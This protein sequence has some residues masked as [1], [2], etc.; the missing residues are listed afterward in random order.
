MNREDFIEFG[1]VTKTNRKTAEIT[2]ATEVALPDPPPA[3]EIIFLEIDGGLVP[4]FLK[5]FDVRA[6]YA[7]GLVEDY[8]SPDKAQKL[9]GCRVFIKKELLAGGSDEIFYKAIIGF[10]VFDQTLGEI[11]RIAE[12]FETPHQILLQVIKDDREILIPLVE[13]FT[14]SINKRKK[15]LFMD[16][17]EGLT[18][19]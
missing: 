12:I 10:A 15:Q 9:V 3:F 13:E 2:I 7:V 11:G 19:L 5:E 14:L 6:N 4:F 8:D 17:P 16:L 18:E 1:K